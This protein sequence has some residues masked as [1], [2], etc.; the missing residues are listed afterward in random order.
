MISLPRRPVITP[1]STNHPRMAP[2]KG[3]WSR[4]K[5]NKRP[6]PLI[7]EDNL[8]IRGLRPS[9]GGQRDAGDTGLLAT[10]RG[11]GAGTGLPAKRA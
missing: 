7:T 5:I 1:N 3:R 9:V 6:S 11:Q 8:V 2:I 10:P 4:P